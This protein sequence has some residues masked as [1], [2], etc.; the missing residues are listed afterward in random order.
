MN[1]FSNL[2]NTYPGRDSVVR[3]LSYLSLYL[4]GHTSGITSRKLKT[5]SDELNYCRLIL[6]LFD[7]IPMLRFTLTY[8]LGRE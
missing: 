3:T 5:I 8:G 6:R 2:L 1:S 7:D 4:S